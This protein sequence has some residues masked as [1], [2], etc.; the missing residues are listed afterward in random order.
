MNENLKTVAK[1]FCMTQA[2]SQ[3]AFLSEKGSA[4]VKKAFATAFAACSVST[5]LSLSL[6][7]EDF[8]F[9]HRFSVCC[10]GVLVEISSC[11]T[12]MRWF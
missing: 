3:V 6:C 4:L 1:T 2:C 12:G 5:D 10:L 9:A 7:T 8:P 11:G